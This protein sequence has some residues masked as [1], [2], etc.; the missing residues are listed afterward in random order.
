MSLHTDQQNDLPIACTL[1]PADLEAMLGGL[2]PGLVG[3]AIRKESIA[4]GFRWLFN[5]D[6]NLVK[7][8]AEVIEA[9]NR[10]CRFLRFHFSV[11]PGEEPLNLEVTGPE[12]TVEFLSTLLENATPQISS[13][14]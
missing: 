1:K 8:I 5:P 4:G 12:G 14:K 2:L 13:N 9:E 10:C 7:E 11:G 3:K 6:D